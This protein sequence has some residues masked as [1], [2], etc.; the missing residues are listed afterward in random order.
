MGTARR[1]VIKGTAHA[2]VIVTGNGADRV[3]GGGGDDVICTGSGN[4]FVFGNAGGDLING[5]SGA[6]SINSGGG[7]F[8]D[9]IGGPGDDTLNGGSDREAL[10]DYSTAGAAVNVSLTTGRATGGAGNDTLRNFDSIQG[11]D[12]DDVL[13]GNSTAFGNGLFG[14][15]GN[16]TLTGQGGPDTLVGE[17]GN[18]SI[19]GGTQAKGEMDFAGYRFAPGPVVVDLSN[20][21]ATGW[22][23]DTLTNIEGIG[24][25]D[26]FGDSLTGDANDNVLIPFGGS[27][28][29]DGGQG[30]D[31]AVYSS[32]TNNMTIDL[33]TGVATGQGSDTLT[34][35]EDAQGGPMDDS[36][37]GTSA[38]NRLFAGPGKDTISGAA[39]D[40]EL[41]GGDG[42]DSLD[43]GDGDDTCIDGEKD[44]NCETK[45]PVPAP[46]GLVILRLEG[47]HGYR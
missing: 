28:H 25:S 9:V 20:G 5:G 21:T 37:T 38:A 33:S 45:E 35:I 32:A 15:A 30:E 47:L 24:G 36:I 4:D 6:D 13:D 18:D 11:S 46:L 17:A 26:S 43:G 42:T 8:D 40:D 14:G 12:F 7:F 27:D 29:L 22:G 10:V 3:S 1:D 41:N 31:L 19:D 2:D 39:G 16:D 34:N 44:I 23:T